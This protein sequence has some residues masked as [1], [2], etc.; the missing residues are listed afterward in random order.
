METFITCLKVVKNYTGMKLL[1]ALTVIA[2]IY[3]F[4]KEKNKTMRVVFVYMPIIV[5]GAVICPITY[6]MFEITH[7]DTAI[8]YR[9]LWVVPMAM[10]TVY[11]I[12]KVSSKNA[13]TR[14]IAVVV[15]SGLFILCGK[16]IYS[17]DRMYESENEYAI[18][19]DTI[20]VVDRI[21]ADAPKRQRITVLCPSILTLY[22]RQYDAD[23]CMPYG[24]EMF[25]INNNYSIPIFEEFEQSDPIKMESL[26]EQSREYEVEYIVFYAGSNTDIDP[27]DAGLKYIDTI[28][29]YIIYKDSHMSAIID[30]WSKYYEE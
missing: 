15:A 13:L 18:P 4:L 26:L 10:I 21:R 29:N 22:V 8:Y 30:E 7:L 9:I 19:Q 11:A 16:C 20:W 12:V 27:A 3:L 17:S 14:M 6:Y 1:F 5:V 28:G 24:R 2:W 23:I 25:D